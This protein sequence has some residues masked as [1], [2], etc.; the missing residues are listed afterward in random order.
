M[1]VCMGCL[2]EIPASDSVCKV[3]GF[4]NSE[5]QSA[6]LLPYGTVLNN[7]YVVA[8]DTDTNGEST[9]YLGYDK[10]TGNVISIREFLPMGLFER[11]EDET[12]LFVAPQDRDNFSKALDDFVHY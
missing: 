4:N 11:G 10:T 7:K 12:K 5:K 9:H 3:C 6:P 8:R 1:P 2:N